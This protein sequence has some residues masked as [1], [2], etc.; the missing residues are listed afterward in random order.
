MKP[1]KGKEAAGLGLNE[2]PISHLF[3]KHIFET[4]NGC[5][6]QIFLKIIPLQH[7]GG[8]ERIHNAS[9][10]GRHDVSPEKTS[11]ILTSCYRLK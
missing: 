9:V 2:L 8:L 1:E 11:G 6:F 3:R 5:K 10:N 7:E 4:L